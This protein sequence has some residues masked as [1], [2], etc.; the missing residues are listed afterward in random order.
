LK[1]CGQAFVSISTP[2]RPSN[3]VKESVEF[4]IY[5]E[6]CVKIATSPLGEINGCKTRKAPV[7]LEWKRGGLAS[8]TRYGMVI[9]VSRCNGC[10]NC[11]IA[12][13]DEYCGNDYPPYSLSQPMTGQFW[14]RLREKER[15]KYPKVKVAYTAIPCMH[16]D[17]P[18][19]VKL[20]PEGAIY[21]RNDGIV[22][23][24]PVKAAGH[25]E[26]VSTCPYRVI[27]W[28]EEKLTPQKCTMCAHLLDDGWK[29]PR[30]V[31]ACPTG[32]LL[33]G[34]LDDP[35]S[36]V[37]QLVASG[38]TEP[39]NSE[40]RMKEKVH[41]I[42]LPRRFVAG[43]V[44]FGD[45]D[46]CAENVNITVTGEGEKRSVLTNNYGDF[47]FEDLAPDKNYSV[48]VEVQGYKTRTFEVKT[49]TDVYLGDIFLA[50]SG[51]AKR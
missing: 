25:K 4:I 12:C 1:R 39:L 36:D 47:E 41:Y 5:H 31:E 40:Y 10:Y 18:S 22:I 45:S 21:K 14:M 27:Y 26:L 13:K 42:G 46:A 51:T 6:E 8:M 3:R 43:A 44:V 33:F 20:A 30:C 2:V 9:D 15:G 11:F 49:A 17:S 16:C 24:D 23:I 28:N 7:A 37:A 32:A 19:C 35:G 34:D 48:K 50:K 38:K 29:E